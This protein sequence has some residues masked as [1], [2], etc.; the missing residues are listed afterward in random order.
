MLVVDLFEQVLDIVLNA[1]LSHR[2]QDRLDRLRLRELIELVA[3]VH[4]RQL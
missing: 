2:R 3:A 1:V 4:A